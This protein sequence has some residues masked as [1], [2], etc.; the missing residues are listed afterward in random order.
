MKIMVVGGAG[1]I[2][3]HM[4][5]RLLAEQHAVDVVDDLSTGTLGNLASARSAGGT[6]KI[7]HLDAG[8]AEFVALVSMREPEVVVHL[9]LLAPGHDDAAHM[10]ASVGSTL[11]VIEAV[12]RAG[13]GK[14][15]VALPGGSLYGEVPSREQPI[16]DGRPF[17]PLDVR[18][19]IAQTVVELLAIAR[20]RHDVE[21]TALAMASVYGPRQRVDGGVVA[22]FVDAVVRNQPVTIVGDGRQARDFLF[23][24]DAVDALV[25]ATQRGG[26]LVVNI[27][28]GTATSIRD[29]WTALAGPS[30]AP[31]QHAP[32]RH[33]DLARVSL[34]PTRARI[35]LAWAPW[36]ALESGLRAVRTLAA[37]T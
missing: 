33:D 24:D 29:L 25:R 2:G 11:N 7:H 14:I 27:G 31:P 26:G 1:F 13:P 20:S 28:T 18:G 34:S 30:A 23:I 15:V 8:A 35:H 22:T 21:F 10:A 5:D 4:V 16:K 9:G 19:V 37:D 17:A 32:Q 36:T 6:L 12:R 3:S